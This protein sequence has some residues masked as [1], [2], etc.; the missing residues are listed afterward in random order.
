MA[1]KSG[2]VATAPLSNE[3]IE[4]LDMRGDGEALRT[5]AAL[6]RL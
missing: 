4:I 3:L 6:K 1:Y 5:T 2:A